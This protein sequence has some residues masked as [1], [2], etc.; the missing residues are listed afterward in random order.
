MVQIDLY[1]DGQRR[2]RCR[3]RHGGM[4]AMFKAR[5]RPGR[6]W[7]WCVCMAVPMFWDAVGRRMRPAPAMRGC[8]GMAGAD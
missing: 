7:S 1:P 3:E 8:S 4:C 5:L 6:C 2:L